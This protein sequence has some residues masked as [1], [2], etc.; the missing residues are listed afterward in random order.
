MEILLANLG[1]RNITFKGNTYLDF[2]KELK[3]EIGTFREWTNNLLKTFENNQKFLKLNILDTLLDK[4]IHSLDKIILFYSDQND[5]E[6][7]DQD[8]IHEA[9]IVKRLIIEK[10]NFNFLNISLVPVEGSVVDN[11]NLLQFYRSEI[12]KLKKLNDENYFIICDAGGTAQQKQALKIIAEF[13]L[14]ENEYEIQYINFTGKI[15]LVSQREYRKII[16]TE[17]AINLIQHGYFSAA[18][19]LLGIKIEEA[20]NQQW[21]GKLLCS[22]IHR[23]NSNVKIAKNL[24]SPNNTNPMFINFKSGKSDSKSTY[25]EKIFGGKFVVLTDKL[26]K[27][28][29]LHNK[30]LYSESILAFAQFYEYYLDLAINVVCDKNRFGK[31]R[32][33]DLNDFQKNNLR[34]FFIANYSDYLERKPGYQPTLSSINTQVM[35]LKVE[36]TNSVKTFAEMISPF[37]D[38]TDDCHSSNERIITKVRNRIAH[39]GM[40]ISHEDMQNKYNYYLQLLHDSSK[41]CELTYSD[42]F[43]NLADVLE[44]SLRK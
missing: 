34:D 4:T 16:L 17:Q 15:D 11:E 44:I 26:Y 12:K 19:Q 41:I 8:T 29:F 24:I 36:G 38:W 14:R 22:V 1:N 33:P 39:E 6:K 7:N 43:Q 35:I 5:E 28:I 23:F 37:V 40:L 18:A 13:L 30:L 10:Y 25:L 27:A 42:L 21:N 3:A 32:N 2:D 31:P 9:E 20:E